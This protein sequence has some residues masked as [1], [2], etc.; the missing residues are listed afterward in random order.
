MAKGLRVILSMEWQCEQLACANALPAR[1]FGLALHGTAV[2]NMIAAITTGDVILGR[3]A[4]AKSFF[5]NSNNG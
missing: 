5:T 2:A 3:R 1:T 4:R